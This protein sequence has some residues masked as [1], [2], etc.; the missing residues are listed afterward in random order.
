M[1]VAAEEGQSTIIKIK[2]EGQEGGPWWPS[3]LPWRWQKSPQQTGNSVTAPSISTAAAAVR[4]KGY[5]KATAPVWLSQ[6]SSHNNGP[7]TPLHYREPGWPLSQE[8]G[9][10]QT[11]S[12]RFNKAVQM[13]GALQ[14]GTLHSVTYCTA[15]GGG[16]KMKRM[17]KGSPAVP[18]GVI[19]CPPRWTSLTLQGLYVVS[20]LSFPLW[21]DISQVWKRW[22]DRERM[23]G[24]N[25]WKYIRMGTVWIFS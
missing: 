15:E 2:K 8:G 5:T 21:D 24:H 19:S 12:G 3:R 9:A 18:N 20:D 13:W 23:M 6:Q 22:E 17:E 25:H 16:E 14:N 1:E 10:A 11:D 7:A 4:G